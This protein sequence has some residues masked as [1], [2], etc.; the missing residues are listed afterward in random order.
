MLKFKDKKGA[1]VAVLGDEDNSPQFI[2]DEVVKSEQEVETDAEVP[3]HGS[4]E[5]PGNEEA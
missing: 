1:V 2:K 3:G 4:S 5:N